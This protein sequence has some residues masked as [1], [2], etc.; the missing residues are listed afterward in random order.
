MSGRSAPL[1]GI[2][3]PIFNGETHV[4]VSIESLL[5]QTVEDIEIV[6]SDNHS[7]DAT[8]QI[9]RDFAARDPR[10]R[11]V[12]HAENRGVAWNF[13]Q[14]FHLSRGR[15]FKWASS[16][17][18]HEPQYIRRCLEVMESD[19]G[20]VLAYPKTSIIDEH[21][22][23]TGT[24]EDKLNLWWPQAPRRFREYLRRVGLCNALYGLMRPEI[25]RRTALLGD[26]PGSDMIFL[27]ELSFHGTFAEVPE[28]LFRRRYD[29]QSAI[30][31]A[32]LENW[33]QFFAPATRGKLVMRTWRH[34]FEYLKA[35]LRSPLS[36][37]DKARVGGI[38]ARNF[39]SV[40]GAVLRELV[41]AARARASRGR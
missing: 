27:G 34:Q 5:A 19:A 13:N 26:Y 33:Q 22:A 10:I 11:Y 17:D 29:P 16:N 14:A 9:C 24:Y 32:T 40:R 39:V 36:P 35:D 28:F 41:G 15:Y 4:A 6:I 30:R 2:G 21:G 20:A 3:L 7:T 31:N 25:L 38:I 12:R 1:I 23:V 8:E 18:I 37:F